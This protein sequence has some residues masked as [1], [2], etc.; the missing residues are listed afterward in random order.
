M[1][2]NVNASDKHFFFSFFYICLNFFKI[3][4]NSFFLHFLSSNFYNIIEFIFS[5]MQMLIFCF[6]FLRTNLTVV[7]KI[8]FIFFLTS[9]CN[10]IVTKNKK[11]TTTKIF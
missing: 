11:K 8:Y 5:Q 3:M 10:F 6:D 9:T 1:S 4:N 2:V 7:L